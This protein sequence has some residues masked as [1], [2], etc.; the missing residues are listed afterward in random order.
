[1]PADGQVTYLLWYLLWY[2]LYQH[3]LWCLLWCRVDCISASVDGQP[4]YKSTDSSNW[5]L[6]GAS[7][8]AGAD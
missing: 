2:F 7:I 3:C 6:N 4:S 8:V 1:M 5:Q